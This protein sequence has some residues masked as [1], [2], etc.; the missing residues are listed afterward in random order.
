M[1]PPSEIAATARHWHTKIPYETSER[2]FTRYPSTSTSRSPMP[3]SDSPERPGRL[4]L[5]RRLLDPYFLPN[6]QLNAAAPGFPSRLL[7]VHVLRRVD[8]VSLAKQSGN[9]RRILL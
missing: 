1:L 9:F 8:V 2:R 3:P 4:A 7:S 6:R 5:R